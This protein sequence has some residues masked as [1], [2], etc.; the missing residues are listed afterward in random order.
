MSLYIC[1]TKP[2]SISNYKKK[3]SY[4]IYRV[5]LFYS[6][7]IALFFPFIWITIFYFPTIFVFILNSNIASV[8][9]FVSAWLLCLLVCM[10][11][12]KG[13]VVTQ[14]VCVKPTGL[15]QLGF[16]SLMWQLFAGVGTPARRA[17]PFEPPVTADLNLLTHTL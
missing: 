13:G 10:F 8:Y 16:M 12:R 6:H 17:Q 11:A 1:I 9:W 2:Y 3:E 7:P 4:L 15:S 5:N 14:R